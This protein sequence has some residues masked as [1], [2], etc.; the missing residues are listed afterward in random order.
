MFQYNCFCKPVGFV[1]NKDTSLANN[2][3]NSCS[4]P[5]TSCIPCLTF[6]MTRFA[7]WLMNNENSVGLSTYP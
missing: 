1:D 6:S 4:T 7:S 5:G 3:I 2:K